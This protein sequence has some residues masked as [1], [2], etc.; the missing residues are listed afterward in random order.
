MKFFLTGAACLLLVAAFELPTDGTDPVNRLLSLG[1]DTTNFD[2]SV[3]PQDDLYR[4]VNG[5]WLDDAHIPADKS[6]YGTI[7]EVVDKAEQDLRAIIEGAAA[8]R[9][10]DPDLRKVGDFYRSFMDSSQIEKLGLEPLTAEFARI[11]AIESKEDLVRYIG[12]SQ[13]AGAGDP[14]AIYV[15]QDAKNTTE[16]ILY[17]TQSGLGLPDREY[18]FDERFAEVRESYAKYIATMSNLAG[19]DGGRGDA[20]T[21]VNLERTLAEHHWTRVRNRDRDA[22]YNKVTAEEASDLAPNLDWEFFLAGAG[23]EDLDAFIIRQ[24]SYFEALSDAL[25]DTPLEDWKTYFRFKVLSNAAPYLPQKFVDERFALYGRA[26][27]GTEQ[28]RPRWKRAVSAADEVLGEVVGKLYVER[29]F[30]SDA[31]ARMDE[32]IENLRSAFRTSITELDWMEPATKLE[33]QE[34]LNKFTPK[35]GYPDSW[36][37]YAA[38]PIEPDDLLGNIYRS[39]DFEYRRGIDKLGQPVDRSEWFMT[40]QTVNA[41]YSSTMNEIVFPAAILQPPFFNVEADDA[42]NYGAIGA[43]IGHEFSHGF[44]DQGRKSD[45][46]GNLRDWWTEQD[47]EQFQKRAAGLVAQYSRFS[48]VEGMHVNGELTL[49]ENIGDLAGLTMAYRAYKLSLGGNEAPDID[50]FTGDQRFFLGWAQVWRRAY[51]PDELK[52]RLV[53]DSHSPSEYRSNGVVRNMPEFYAAFNVR[54]GDG[55]YLPQDERVKIW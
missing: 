47:N 8:I 28:D 13:R 19:W 48:P 39:Q 18:Y 23:I 54:E 52:R 34:K 43:V 3:R 32:M 7:I 50:G 21:I 27:R 24:P 46:D 53:T 30:P 5:A 2:R 44:D 37:D 51:R 15:T 38:L 29:H 6:S 45:G 41:Y 26:I 55:M 25:V 11:D 33:A 14:F 36:K 40:P 22:T 1:I 42:V 9:S 35:I 16:Y 17:V 31:K 49:G 4:F 10:N 12:Y 20:E